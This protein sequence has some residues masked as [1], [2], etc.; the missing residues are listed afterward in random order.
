V[1]PVTVAPARVT[2]PLDEVL[3]A[4]PRT[5]LLRLGLRHQTFAFRAGQAVLAGRHGQVVRKPY[6]I[7]CAPH[8]AAAEQALELL[9]QV[10]AEAGEPHLEALAPGMLVDVEGPF[11][12]FTLPA[13]LGAEPL[14]LLAGGTGIAPLRAMLWEE[15]DAAAPRPVTVIYSARRREEFAFVG[16]LEALAGAGRIALH[17]TVTRQGADDWTGYRGRVDAGLLLRLRPG[18]DARWLLCGPPAFVSDVSLE[19]QA[20][21]VARDHIVVER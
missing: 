16:E 3:V 21:G 9:V 1:G 2:L 13:S 20:L 14:V 7:A 10:D 6:S 12:S 15:L 8:Q 5:R 19:L 17:L 11:G 18:P 4:T